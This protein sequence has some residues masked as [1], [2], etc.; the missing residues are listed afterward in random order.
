MIK[1]F[2]IF[3]FRFE[4]PILFQRRRGRSQVSELVINQR[5]VEVDEREPRL[6]L[7]RGFIVKFCELQ[8]AG[9]IIKIGQVLVSFD[10]TRIVFE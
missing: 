3:V 5:E 10:V 9:I 7:G 1:H 6:D 2:E 8:I 4:L